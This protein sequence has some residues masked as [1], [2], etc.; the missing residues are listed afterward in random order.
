MEAQKMT[1]GLIGKNIS[2]SFSKAYFTQKF[3]DLNLENCQYLNFDLDDISSFKALFNLHKNIS[4]LNV[5]IPYKQEIMPFLDGLSEE[6]QQI[7]AVNTI[8]IENGKLIG[9]N[10]DAYGFEQSLK[11]VIT[12]T[13]EKALIL[14]WGGASKAVKFVLLKLGFEV[15]I[16]SRNNTNDEFLTYKQLTKE[17]I[18]QTKLIV[19]CT[20]LG[21]F[22][23]VDN[24]PDIPYQYLN[25]SHVLFDLIYNPAE[26]K[27]LQSGKEC[28]AKIKNGAD[29]LKFQAEKAWEIWN[30]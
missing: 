24:C 17:L 20:P 28:G 23:R 15:T 30:A 19:N 7:G 2:Y 9:Y 4:G 26:T 1:Y 27:F 6:A 12:K 14:G 16:V 22:P 29:M 5:T 18:E 10:T 21:T 11:S 3:K 8:K 13:D 25:K